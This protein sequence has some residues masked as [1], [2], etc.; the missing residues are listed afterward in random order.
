M[1]VM[2]CSRF[3]TAMMDSRP[4]KLYGSSFFLISFEKQVIWLSKILFT[5]LLASN[6][7]STFRFA[8]FLQWI[9]YALKFLKFE[10]QIKLSKFLNGVNFTIRVGHNR[11]NFI[12]HQNLRYFYILPKNSILTSFFVHFHEIKKSKNTNLTGLNWKFRHYV[13][14]KNCLW[15][16]SFERH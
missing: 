15:P 11:L 9:W 10:G 16:Q 3:M 1:Q 6:R 12:F 13:Q 14:G 5:W 7:S 2:H 8:S 4:K